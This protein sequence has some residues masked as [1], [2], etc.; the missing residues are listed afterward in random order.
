MGHAVPMPELLG[1]PSYNDLCR[2]DHRLKCAVISVAGMLAI[3]QEQSMNIVAWP[4][5]CEVMTRTVRGQYTTVHTICRMSMSQGRI[6]V[7]Y[8]DRRFY[9]SLNDPQA[10]E[11]LCQRIAAVS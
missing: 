5:Y 4:E 9:A 6:W 11:K 3:T 10:G 2:V 7:A 1:P 8:K